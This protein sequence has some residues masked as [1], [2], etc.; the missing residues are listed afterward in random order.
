MIVT[1]LV[2]GVIGNWWGELWIW[3]TLAVRALGMWM[4]MYF[5]GG[6]YFGLVQAAAKKPL[7][8]ARVG[9]RATTALEAYRDVRLGWRPRR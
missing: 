5:W 2:L 1:G 9:Q 4:T 8:N 7:K 6:G 3:V